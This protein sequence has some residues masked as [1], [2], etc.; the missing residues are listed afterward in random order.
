MFSKKLIYVIGIALLALFVYF[1]GQFIM[2]MLEGRMEQ[3]VHSVMEDEPEEAEQKEVE[4]EQQTQTVD[5]VIDAGHGGKDPGK[6]GVGGVEEKSVNLAIALLV[7]ERL[8][9]QGYEVLMTRTEDKSAQE[10]GE[11][12]SNIKDLHARVDLINETEP[13]LA[14]S[15]HQNSYQD[16][17]IKGAQVFYYHN[18]KQGEE[19]AHIMQEE[20]LAL[21]LDNTRQ[22]KGNDSYFMLKRTSAPLI[23]VECGFLTNP[24]E[25]N[26]LTT[27]EYQWQVADC[28]VAGI[29]NYLEQGGL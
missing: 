5:I 25:G 18:S 20:L 26:L 4:K 8:V 27:E 1:T 10:S 23:I 7:E 28:I 11:E 24:E 3:S 17:S 15:I 19:A 22:P 12:E 6:I 9:E 21:N 29:K 13:E 14:V 16:S 2:K